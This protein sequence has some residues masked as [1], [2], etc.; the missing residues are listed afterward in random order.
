MVAEAY[1]Y[2][3]NYKKDPKNLT[4][5][6][7][8]NAGGNSLN[9]GV[10]FAQDGGKEDDVTN[11][12]EQAFTT[13]GGA[14]GANNQKKVCRRCGTDGHTSVKCNSGKDKIGIYLQLQQANQGV[15]QLIHAVDWNGVNDEATN[16][17]FLQ[18]SNLY[19]NYSAIFQSDGPTKCTE[20]NNKNGTIARTH[21][22]TIFSQ[23][24]S[25]IPNT[26]YLLDNQ[27]TCDIVSNP[28]LVKNI[29]QVEGNMQLATQAGSTTTNW[30]ADV[31]GYHQPVWFH[32]GGIANILSMVNMIA[33]YRV[34]YVSHAGKHPNQFCVHKDDGGIHKF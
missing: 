7:G 28:K 34:T 1:D 4:Q 8:H 5:L 23:A 11:T 6:P 27:S 14:G 19:K 15:S 16:W 20:Y 25:G 17:I 31:P 2:L 9:T 21:K 12:Q 18:E 24:N 29:R 32:P 26:W 13:T 3:C 22:S 30:M 33:K 10:A